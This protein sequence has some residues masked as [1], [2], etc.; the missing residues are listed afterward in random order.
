MVFHRHAHPCFLRQGLR[1]LCYAFFVLS[2]GRRTKKEGD[3]SMNRAEE[4]VFPT[5]N[6]RH[7]EERLRTGV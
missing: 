1:L 3:I 5:L 4:Q 7:A 6:Y 2:L